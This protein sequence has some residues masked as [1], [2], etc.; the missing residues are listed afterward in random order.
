MSNH[1]KYLIRFFLQ[2]CILLLFMASCQSSSN[3]QAASSPEETK[4]ESDHD[5]ANHEEG[6]TTL[7][8]EQMKSVG[9]ELGYVEQ[10]QLGGNLKVNGLLTVPNT[11]KANATSLF[12]GVIQT[13]KVELGDQVRKGQVIASIVNP[14]FIQ[15]QE[16]YITINSRLALAEQEQSRQ[17]ELYDGNVGARKNLQA[18]T[19]ELNALR[20]RKSSLSRQ[21]QMMGINPSS[22]SNA[23][24]QS[25]ILVKS[26]INGVISQVFAKIGSYV[27][28][29]SAI[30]EIV[31]NTAL[32]LDLQVFEKD[33]PYIHIGQKIDFVITNNPSK[34]YAAELYNIGASFDGNNKTIAV[35][36]R[37]IG[38]KS[39]LIDGMNVT[40]LLHQGTQLADAVPDDAI[41]N[42]DGK[43]YVFLVQAGEEHVHEE[44][45]A[46]DHAHADEKGMRFERIEI[47]KGASEMG[48][49]AITPVKEMPKAAQIVVKSAF[50]VN[51]KMSTVGHEHA[52]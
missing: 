20:A 3:Q 21:I 51:A 4:E 52:H 8:A 5:E 47:Q 25:T 12:S 19:T 48:Y 46:P 18:A 38:D 11:N 35:H 13:L 39:G 50:F 9:I 27:D 44:T 36:C 49:T 29:S 17:Q 33:M 31:E 37:I 30:I 26:P 28:V 14:D 1:F 16:E 6:V 43:Y 22:I 7:T 42:A 24:L 41:V 15:L 45:E 23:N 32:H 10:K 2:A 34:T 40:G